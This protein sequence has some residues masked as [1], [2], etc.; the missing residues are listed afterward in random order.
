MAAIRY[1][2][3]LYELRES[4]SVL[5]A[6]LRAGVPARHSCKAGSCGSC[7]M[8]AVDGAVPAKAQTGLKDSW[9]A[10]GYF[11]AC[12]CH[13]DS[14]LEVAAAEDDAEVPATIT[15]LD[16]LADDV[17]RVR[18]R[19]GAPF[20]FRA[21]QYVTLVRDC[22]LA[23]SYSI[24]SL[25]EEGE[26]ELHVR[27]IPNGRMSGW[28]STEAGAG[29][30]VSLLGPSGECFYVP[31]REDQ[32]MILVGT[33]TGLAPLYGI[34]RDALR[35]GHRGPIQLFH[36]AVRR[37]GLYLH[38]HLTRLAAA[39]A[40][41]EYTASVLEAPDAGDAV[42][43]PIDQLILRRFPNLDG[44]RGFLCGD[45]ALVGSLRKKLFLAGIASRDIYA[46]A[47]LPSAT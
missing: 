37:D 36:G 42:S 31:G 20:E 35:N 10:R 38:D 40:N 8:R 2:D 23:R 30:P 46:D 5:D 29:T 12:V 7:M 39:H 28:L 44:W 27:R 43:G 32:P 9:K 33:G 45:P 25:P 16:R 6:L 3:R 47:F 14:D 13:P 22:Q 11:L 19:C 24:A 34:V 15:S 18:L 41:L 21:G 17:L 4:E 26:I 1:G